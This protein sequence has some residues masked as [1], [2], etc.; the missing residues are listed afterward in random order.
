[1][2][3]FNHKLFNLLHFSKLEIRKDKL[4][5]NK[6]S[7]NFNLK[8]FLTA[9]IALVATAVLW[10]LPLDSFGIEGL[11]VVHRRI[12]AI[13]VFATIMWV[14]EC[15]PS[16][17][18]SVTLIFLLLFATSDSGLGFFTSGLEKSELLSHKVLMATFADP[19]IILFLGGFILATA[20]TKSGLDVVLAR[21]LLRP[22]G[23]KSEILLLGF[24]LITGI[25][26]M[27]ISNTATAAMMLTFLAPV[28]K[29]LPADGKGR[30]ALTLAIPLGAN[31]GGIATPIGTPPNMIALKYLNDPEGL[32]LNI[33]FGEW[34]AYM[35]PLTIVLLIIG[36]LLILH[37]FPFKQK[38]IELEIGGEVQHNW[39]TV[40]VVVTFAVTIFMWL[41]DKLTGVNANTVAMLPIAVF[42][43]TGVITAKDL[44][45]INWSVIW[46]VAGGFALGVALN[47]SGLAESAIRSI[48]FDTWSPVL[49]LI[50][51]L[52][53][54]YVL[55][56]FI[57]HTATTA[58]LVPIL[59]VVCKGMGEQL[60]SIGGVTTVLVGLAIS[61]SVSM[62]L[63]ISTPPNAIAHSTGLVK[64]EEMMKL[65]ICVGI[66]GMVLGYVTLCFM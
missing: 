14:T 23:T 18:T 65:G 41:F 2:S 33:G 44:Q 21:A 55:S 56:N 59:A 9:V 35:T 50:I 27:F 62:C 58:L 15:I 3:F 17:A 13:F 19:I 47:E 37:F 57:S 51:A 11:T 31:I 6:L 42:A 12:I 10:N 1:M 40:V 16:W 43:A 30:V 53:V 46:M 26:S 49:I 8:I 5:K 39:R 63:P 20:A 34:M 61:A 25:F 4:V 36:W 22:F 29:A 32:N 54:C 64:Q 45:E 60:N 52:L 7:K 38:T 66:I 24:I 48:P 28:F